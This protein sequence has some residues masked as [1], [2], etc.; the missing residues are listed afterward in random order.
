MPPEK[1]STATSDQ[2]IVRVPLT[3][4]SLFAGIGGFD[5]GL[6]R[7]GM[8]CKWQVEIEPKCSTWLRTRWPDAACASDVSSFDAKGDKRSVGVICG[9]FPCQNL[10]SA[11]V[12]TRAGLNGEKSGLWR[13]FSRIVGECH[14]AWV[15]VE[16]V[17]TWRDWMPTVRRDLWRLG[18]ASVSVQLCPSQFGAYHRR[19]RVF[20]VANANC[21]SESLSAIHAEVASLRPA[22]RSIRQR[23]EDIGGFV[24]RVDGLSA[25]MARAYGNAVCPVVAEW[26]GRRIVAAS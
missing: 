13:E 1:T 2:P 7:A 15:V 18:Y 11:N 23:F 4:G 6:E 5:L 14:P 24:P 21:K 25:W 9:G 22:P 10:S 17:A 12:K 8:V 16:N 20:V 19:P 3:F 26:I